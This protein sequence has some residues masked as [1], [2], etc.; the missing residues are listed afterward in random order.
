LDRLR[1]AGVTVLTPDECPAFAT[2]EAAMA[3]AQEITMGI[4]AW[5]WRWPL[6][7]FVARD[8]SALSPSAMETACAFTGV[9]AGRVCG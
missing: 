9:Y 5:E 2:V 8:A 3:K 4:N 7:S 1:A 6:G